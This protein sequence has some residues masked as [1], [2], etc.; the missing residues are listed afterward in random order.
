MIRPVFRLPE[1]SLW[2]FKINL[3]DQS[4]ESWTIITEPFVFDPDVRFFD[5]LVPTTETAKFGYIAEKLF[6][7]NRPVMFTGDT[8]VGKSVLAKTLLRRLVENDVIPVFLNFS[9]QTSSIGTQVN[10]MHLQAP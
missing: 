3:T 10:C 2:D 6:R 4:W 1:M 5:V 9:A 8:G 7:E